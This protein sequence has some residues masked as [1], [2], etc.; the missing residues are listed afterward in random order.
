MKFKNMPLII[1]L[2]AGLITSITAV[3]RKI[4]TTT[5]LTTLFFVLLSFYVL[6]LLARYIINKICFPKEEEKAQSE[7]GEN[8]T[9]GTGEEGQETPQEES[10][11]G[12]I[13]S[14]Y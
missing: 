4:D 14:K 13:I 12:D 10:S 1:M 8:D 5:A 7:D 6:G 3:I 2:V 11:N 9:E